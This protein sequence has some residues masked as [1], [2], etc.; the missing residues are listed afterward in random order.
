[1][2]NPKEG[3][4]VTCN[5]KLASEKVKNGLGTSIPTTARAI[6][7][8][9]LLLENIRAGKKLNVEIMKRIQNDVV[10]EYAALI[11][12]KLIEIVQKYKDK[13]FLPRSPEM[14]VIN[15]TVEILRN[16]KGDMGKESKEAL[17]YSTWYNEL[18]NSML[19]R[20]IRDEFERQSVISFFFSDHFIGNKVFHWAKGEQTRSILCDTA[21]SV[22]F[23]HPC[24]YNVVN[25][26]LRARRTIVKALGK[27]E[28]FQAL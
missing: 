5:N 21:E 19:R 3:F 28:V 27:N 24:I 10:D 2:I 6:R 25:A 23:S 16:W 4:V 18:Y 1:M 22:D 15:R 11:S 7:V 13:Y 17:V 8:R 20:V 26:I 12:P 14:K 9:K